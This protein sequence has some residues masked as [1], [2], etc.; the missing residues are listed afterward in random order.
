MPIKQSFKNGV[1]LVQARIDFNNLSIIETI[2]DDCI[3]DRNQAQST[4]GIAVATYI[5]SNIKY[6]FIW[7]SKTFN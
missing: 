4:F 5:G 6:L 3:G 1:S 7:V 2:I